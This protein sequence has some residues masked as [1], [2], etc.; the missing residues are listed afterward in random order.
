MLSKS[1]VA[2]ALLFASAVVAQTTIQN[3]T[4][5][6]TQLTPLTKCEIPFYACSFRDEKLTNLSPMV[7]WSAKFLS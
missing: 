6:P 5:D 4:V 2:V 3:F 1:T 7:Q